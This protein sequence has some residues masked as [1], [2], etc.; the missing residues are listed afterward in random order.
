MLVARVVVDHSIVK[1]TYSPC[2]VLNAYKQKHNTSYKGT[3]ALG[4]HKYH[5]NF[6]ATPRYNREKPKLLKLGKGFIE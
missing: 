2:F 6:G 4:L 1:A 5:G 3:A